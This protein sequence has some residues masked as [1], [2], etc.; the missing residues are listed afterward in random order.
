[1]KLSG[2]HLDLCDI[3]AFWS[4]CKTNLKWEETLYAKE[5]VNVFDPR[6]RMFYVNKS[7]IFALKKKLSES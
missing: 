2:S 1:M 3:C 6:F 4:N 5:N 7:N